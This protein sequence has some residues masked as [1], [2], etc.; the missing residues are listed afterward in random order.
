MSE[1]SRLPKVDVA[2]L[3]RDI[4]E[5]AGEVVRADRIRTE[6]SSLYRDGRLGDW[7]ATEAKEAV[8]GGLER[9]PWSA[10]EVRDLAER[11]RSELLAST[12]GVRRVAGSPVCVE[13]SE[14]ERGS[15]GYLGASQ[16]GAA[17]WVQMATAAGA[18]NELW[19]ETCESWVGIP[20]DLAPGNYVALNVRGDS[21]VPLLHDGD[22]VLI[23]LGVKPRNGS[24]VVARSDEGYVVKRL[25]RITTRGVY[26]ESLNPDYEPMVIKDVQQP[27]AGCVVLSWCPHAGRS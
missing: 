24:I 7:L 5:Q 14:A 11:M 1:D 18:G 15:S 2:R 16:R 6:D 12:C 3:A 23:A 9:D 10:A 21:M 26:L 22:T 17:P 4:A 20:D 8:E 25:T 27:I 13:L 19:D